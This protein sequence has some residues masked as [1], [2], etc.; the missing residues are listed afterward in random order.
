[1]TDLIANTTTIHD[2]VTALREISDVESVEIHA[3]DPSAKVVIRELSTHYVLVM[4]DPATG[5]ILD[6]CDTCDFDDPDR[7]PIT[8]DYDNLAAMIKILK[9]GC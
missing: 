6:E 4:I 8:T 5:L 9:E 7:D 3:T 1:M 2:V